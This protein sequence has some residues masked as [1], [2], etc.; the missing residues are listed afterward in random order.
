M[1]HPSGARHSQS[2]GLDREGS[3]S[4]FAAMVRLVRVVGEVS[5]DCFRLCKTFS[6][7]T[8]DGSAVSDD[9][10]ALVAADKRAPRELVTVRLE[11]SEPSA[12]DAATA[13]G[14]VAGVVHVE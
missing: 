8:V 6:A 12:T 1:T 7:N 4:A 5:A 13:L 14:V 3:P 2:A 10:Q 11:L 9:A